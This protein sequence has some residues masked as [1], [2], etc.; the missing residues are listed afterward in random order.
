MHLKKTIFV[1]IL[2]V[3]VLSGCVVKDKNIN[4]INTV[5]NISNVSNDLRNNSVIE[6]KDLGK[7][8]FVED[9]VVGFRYPKWKMKEIDYNSF[10]IL[11][12]VYAKDKDHVFFCY[13]DGCKTLDRD[14]QTYVILD[15]GYYQKDKNGVY[16]GDSKLVGADPNSFVTFKFKGNYYA[17]DKNN[18]Y[19]AGRKIEGADAQTFVFVKQNFARDANNY[20]INDKIAKDVDTPTFSFMIGNYGKDKNSY[21]YCDKY[22][23]KKISALNDNFIVLDEYYA[24]DL[25]KVYYQ[26][27]EISG[28]EP[29]SFEVLEYGYASDK[30]SFYQ[31]GKS[32][33]ENSADYYKLYYE[34]RDISNCDTAKDKRKNEKTFV[35]LGNG[36]SKDDRC[37]YYFDYPIDKSRAASFEVL[38]GNYSRDKNYIYYTMPEKKAILRVENVIPNSF[39]ILGN[40]YARD[41]ERIFFKSQ[42]V[43]RADVK[44]FVM[45]KNN[46]AKDKAGVFFES[47]Y[48]GR[49]DVKTFELIDS[50]S[51]KWGFDGEDKIYYFKNGEATLK[52]MIE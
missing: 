51:N 12:D 50:K 31:A 28:A 21:F 19:F 45:L 36:Y 20:Y 30:N 23:C 4:E 6:Y 33:G 42:I 10:Q 1:T 52:S 3:L 25:L 43:D 14:A 11:S 24:K 37:V 32:Y 35:N 34:R 46:Y 15:D 18:V 5:K 22:E 44:T 41:K 48:L 7:G 13:L 27:N 39:E 2:S 38:A 9:G 26:G 16:N 29:A 40:D 49:A 8:W 47:Q 17:K